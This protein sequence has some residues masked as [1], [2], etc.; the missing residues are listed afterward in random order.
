MKYSTLLSWESK[1]DYPRLSRVDIRP[2]IVLFWEFHLIA[3]LKT[4]FGCESLYLSVLSQKDAGGRG[5]ASPFHEMYFNKMYFIKLMK[6]QT[7]ILCVCVHVCLVSLPSA[8]CQL[9]LP[10]RYAL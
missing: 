10:K 8:V 7:K 3:G 2:H 5:G 4:F 6:Q 1:R 9:I